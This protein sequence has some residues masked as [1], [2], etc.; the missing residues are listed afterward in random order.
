MSYINS[1]SE[2]QVK[3]HRFLGFIGQKLDVK[4]GIRN[5]I[6]KHIFTR[7]LGFFSIFMNKNHLE[8]WKEA[9]GGCLENSLLSRFFFLIIRH[10]NKLSDEFIQSIYSLNFHFT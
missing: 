8:C 2:L 3:E 5:W 6:F 10:N 9:L 4:F 1:P 7:I